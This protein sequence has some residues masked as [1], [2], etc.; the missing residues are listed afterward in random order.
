MITLRALSQRATDRLRDERG[1]ALVVA[2]GV[3]MVVGIL[4][5]V[6]A[7]ASINQRQQ[8]QEDRSSKRALAAAEAGVRRAV[9]RLNKTLPAA[10]ECA[11]DT[12]GA[13]SPSVGGIFCKGHGYVGNGAAYDFYVSRVLTA[14]ESPTGCVGAN[15][16]IVV[17]PSTA[18][19][20][21]QRCVVAVGCVE[22]RVTDAT[23][24]CVDDATGTVRGVH[25]RVQAR[26]G[27]K[28]EIQWFPGGLYGNERLCIARTNWTDSGCSPLV[29]GGQG[30]V[31]SDIGSNTLLG[32]SSSGGGNAIP[33][34]ADEAPPRRAQVLLSETG[35]LSSGTDPD[36]SDNI[37]TSGPGAG[38][39]P[40]LLRGPSFGTAPEVE[41]PF[42]GC[43][44][45]GTDACPSPSSTDT[46]RPAN[47]NNDEF[48]VDSVPGAADG[49]AGDAPA[50][51]CVEAAYK[52]DR[53]L[54]VRGCP[55]G[56]VITLPPGNYNFC[57]IWI[58]QQEL[59]P[60]A[61]ATP[62]PAATKKDPFTGN[63]V[64]IFLDSPYRAGS[65]C[66][67]GNTLSGTAT[68]GTSPTL[69]STNWS[70]N[71]NCSGSNDPVT[72]RCADG[73]FEMTNNSSITGG[74][75]DQSLRLQF[76]AYGNPNNTYGTP[77]NQSCRPNGAAQ[78]TL[79]C[80][81]GPAGGPPL[82]VID[83][84]NNFDIT[85]TLFAPSSGIQLQ[86]SAGN[87]ITV[88]GAIRARD[89]IVGA[90]INFRQDPSTRELSFAIDQRR[91]Y[92]GPWI[93][94]RPDPTDPN[95]PRSAC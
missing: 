45:A 18:L 92:R 93:E 87:A 24:H 57:R 95:D 31:D 41:R 38:L 77:P 80:T 65:G 50:V 47:N 22:P 19:V 79:P 1:V 12:G 32:L 74:I 39:I 73:S 51:Q 55:N 60:D 54:D 21:D 63:P 78:A 20:I 84:R 61:S 89:I 88:G 30:R 82:P 40:Q 75:V 3:L 94:C 71:S 44:G 26:T 85:F 27:A 10:N 25:R 4:S 64:R 53:E 81:G 62:P 90:N 36:L 69:S 28:S 2:A 83:F 33:V 35:A 17:S 67:V 46:A 34:C 13:S 48:L 52:G 8:S 9:Y 68:P 58:G 59:K 14:A 11:G 6:V 29:G 15:Q 42:R 49:A 23:L 56:T 86:N 43:F 72:F 91:Y 76:W 16:R 7:T 66:G 37:C 5:A 70:Q